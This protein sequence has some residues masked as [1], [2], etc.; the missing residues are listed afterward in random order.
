MYEVWTSTLNTKMKCKIKTESRKEA[1][2]RL[3]QF[4]NLL[5]RTKGEVYLGWREKDNKMT[6]LITYWW[7]DYYD[8]GIQGR[9]FV[10]HD[11]YYDKG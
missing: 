2:A 11:K 4:G 7:S 6:R 9:H 5:K 10:T 1:D 8:E 3:K